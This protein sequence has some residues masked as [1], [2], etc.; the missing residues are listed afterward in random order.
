MTAF[1]QALIALCIAWPGIGAADGPFDGGESDFLPVDEAFRP[2][3]ERVGEDELVVGWVIAPDYY[4]YRHAFDFSLIGAGGA[5]LGTLGIPDGERHTDE[6][7]GEVETYREHV[8]VTLP[9]SGRLP[10]GTALRIRYQGCADAGLCY[11]PQ[12]RTLALGGDAGGNDTGDTDEDFVAEQD[13]LAARLAND[14]LVWIAISFFGLGILL[15]FTPCILPMLPILSGLIVGAHT[16]R[17]DRRTGA[18]RG[19][20]LSG[21]YVLA[22][23]A[24]YTV[25]G[26]LAGLAGANLQ[27]ALQSPWVLVPF[28][29]LFVALALAM[30]GVY[31]LQLPTA[32]QERLSAVGGDRPSL[33]GAATLGFLAALIAGPCLAPPLAGALLYIGSS[34]DPW[35]GGMALF[36][37]GLGMG[38]PLIALGT[39]G[40]GVLPRPGPWMDGV[41]V[42]FGVILIGVAL[43]L[44]DRVLPGPAILALWAVLL[45]GYGVYL[46]AL[47]RRQRPV[48][49]RLSQAAGILALIYAGI[50]LVGAASGAGDP[51]RPLQPLTVGTATQAAGE[52]TALRRV[53]DIDALRAALAAAERAGRPAILDFYADWCVEC[54]RME[55]T[56]FSRPEVRRALTDVAALQVDITDYD[57]A[58]RALMRE[59]DVLGPPTVLFFGPDGRERRDYRLIGE[60]DAEGFIERLDR[61][62]GAVDTSRTSP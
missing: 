26:I 30:F 23:A 53:E 5:G 62:L 37:L 35:L 8:S 54:V 20:A 44:L 19:F 31:R 18:W 51:L 45:A 28:S 49:A 50:L 3:V 14:N 6:F 11:P 15:A 34:G 52:R 38:L 59:F 12:T 57:A 48:A 7:F 36:S 47:E 22:M 42:L 56:V 25:F 29:L 27:A 60:T 10:D 9:V 17:T 33:W 32:W 43:W 21:V 61:A 4:L 16:G 39:V 13:R 55:R 41:R 1:R 58:D 46:G 24:A 40:G 2:A